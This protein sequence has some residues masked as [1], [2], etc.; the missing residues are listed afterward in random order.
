MGDFVKTDWNEGIAPG[1][2]AAQLDRQEAGIDESIRILDRDMSQVDVESTADEESIYSHSIAAG[3]LGATGGVR[4]TLAGDILKAAAGTFRIRVKLGST[5]VFVGNS[6][7]LAGHATDRYKWELVLWF[8]N[9]AA[10]AQKWGA[11]VKAI[12]DDVDF[13]IMPSTTVGLT[14]LGAGLGSSSEDTSGAKTIDVTVDWSTSSASL[15]FRKEMAMLEKLP[16]T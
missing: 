11:A 6:I 12:L 3:T 8:M 16:A 5:T 15:S 4:L 9:T 13:T 14:Y 7:S 10:D 2:S 1:I